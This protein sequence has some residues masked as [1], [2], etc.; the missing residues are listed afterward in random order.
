MLYK[1]QRLLGLHPPQGHATPHNVLFIELAEMGSTVL[2]Y[3]AMKRLK[4]LYPTAN[5]HFLLFDQIK[6]SVDILDII[7]H[8]NV[9]TI[10]SKSIYSL[11]RDTLKFIYL[12]RK[13]NID[14]AIILE[15]FTRYGTI[16]SYL[17]GARQRVGFYRYYQEGLYIGHLLSHKVIYNPHIHTSQAFISLVNALGT[18]QEQI[19]FTK[20]KIESRPLEVPNIELSQVEKERAWQILREENSQVDQTKTIVV[21]NPN[22]SKLISLRKWPL[23]YYALLIQKLLDDHNVYVVITGVQSEK[24]DAEFICQYVQS[25]RV[26]DVVGKT[27]LRELVSLFNIGHVL[28]SNDSGPA[29]F[30]ALTNIHIVVFFGP[31][32]PLLYKPLSP[33]CTVLYA[34]YACSPCVSAFN[35]KLSPCTDNA[36]LTSMHTGHVYDVVRTILDAKLQG[37]AASAEG[38]HALPHHPLP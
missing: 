17:S 4:E 26:L 37:K 28:V 20:Y 3:P 30:A 8:E 36:C 35:Q 19:P 24:P 6:E 14:T 9:L 25:D 21:V 22:A 38:A 15:M 2:A 31:E 32:S 23:E 29:H 34:H 11:A 16:L 12:S 13:K 10:N 18:S 5:I 27:T 33:Y 1:L 7:P